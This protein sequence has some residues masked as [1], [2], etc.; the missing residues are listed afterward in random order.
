MSVWLVERLFAVLWGVVG[1]TVV[2][3]HGSDGFFRCAEKRCGGR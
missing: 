2:D 1:C 3:C